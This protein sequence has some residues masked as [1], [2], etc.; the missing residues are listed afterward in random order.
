MQAFSK[1]CGRGVINPTFIIVP[2]TLRASYKLIL[3]DFVK[4]KLLNLRLNVFST[5]VP[6]EDTLFKSFSGD[7]SAF[8]RATRS[9]GHF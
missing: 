9:P 7:L 3:Q 1:G 2:I 5:N 8:L 4:E 6:I